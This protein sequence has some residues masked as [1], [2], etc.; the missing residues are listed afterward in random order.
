MLFTPEVL[1][2]VVSVTPGWFCARGEAGRPG[3]FVF[4][5]VNGL[6]TP[7]C[8]GVQNCSTVHYLNPNR[9]QNLV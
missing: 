6:R 7:T 5:V 8:D 2:L 3:S 9:L 4:V 1:V